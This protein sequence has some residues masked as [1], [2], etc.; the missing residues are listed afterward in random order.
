MILSEGYRTLGA[1]LLAGIVVWVVAAASDAFEFATHA[2]VSRQAFAT[3]TLF[4]G[5]L[6]NPASTEILNQLGLDGSWGDLGFLYLDI[7]SG[8]VV[9]R[10]AQPLGDSQLGPRKLDAANRK[11][12]YAPLL[13]SVPA[14]IML[15][16]IREDDVPFSASEIDNTPQDEVGG[17][18]IRVK[19]HFY[20]PLR[21]LP[22]KI[23]GVE[24]GASAKDWALN[25][26][27]GT[28]DP[29]N[30][31]NVPMAREVMW[32]ALTLKLR[33]T[34]P[35]TPGPLA[36]LGFVATPALGTKELVRKAYW[37]STFRTLGNIVHMVQDMAQPQHTRNDKHAGVG[38]VPPLC[39]AGHKSHFE[40]YVEARAVGA[41]TFTLRERFGW[42][43]GIVDSKFPI[44]A[45]PLDFGAYPVPRFATYEEYFSTGTGTASVS[46]LGL[47]NYSNRGFYSS[48]T[49]PGDRQY[50]FAWP[51][52][53]VGSLV[54]T[55][56]PKDTVFDAANSL[57]K[58]ASL[59]IYSGVVTDTLNPQFSAS[60]APLV[61]H[62]AFDE[63]LGKAA[64]RQFT[65]NHYAYAAQAALLI[66]RA[67]AYSAGLLDFFFR[68]R[69]EISLP[70]EGIYAVRDATTPVCIDACG[71]DRIKLKVRNTRPNEAMGPGI[72]VAVVKFHR[73][74]CYQP[75]LSGEPGG[76]NF[77]G[78]G[79]RVKE[80]EI[81]VSEA[82]VIGGLAANSTIAVTFPFAVGT[83]IPINATDVSLQVVFRGKLGNEDDAVV[84]TTKNIAETNYVAVHNSTDYQR[85]SDSLFE[86][87]PTGAADTF[88]SV[89]IGFGAS[90]P[91]IPVATLA[92]LPAPGYSQLAFLGDRGTTKLTIDLVPHKVS[93]GHPLTYAALPVSEIYLPSGG[94]GYDSTWSVRRTRGVY[95]RFVQSILYGAGTTSYVC[96]GEDPIATC[97][98][99]SL[100]PL[101]PAHARP[102]QIAFN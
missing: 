91:Q 4:A 69:L 21:D 41:D 84:V 59:E 33:P 54:R 37:A 2:A 67:V 57:V 83:P 51:P 102:L 73:N 74:A 77:L 97:T 61:A 80:E 42:G 71:F 88:T 39:A 26:L 89:T 65:L 6:P 36:D 34:S 12:P 38:C 31:F 55:T 1:K 46:G 19:N 86:P 15:G 101:T 47:A 66:P 14:W 32:R 16:S 45:V 24:V 35:M 52:N 43:L 9:E 62:G 10:L 48:G 17:P 79:C 50:A 23:A 72:M 99:S 95:T 53:D 40:A 28:Y 5:T 27:H 100:S 49:L 94:T 64:K 7:G 96:R 8:S 68:G 18:F 75:D 22:L 11:S 20:D 87:T 29:S 63:F 30:H 56:L 3:S 82:K 70:D 25:D 78:D 98:Q 44:A 81:V 76:S 13:P 90:T 92:A 93:F 58:G 60:S 85:L